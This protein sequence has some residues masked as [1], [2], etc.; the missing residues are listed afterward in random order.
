MWGKA[1]WGLPG[2]AASAQV[3][4]FVFGRPFLAHLAGDR[5][6]FTRPRPGYTAFLSRNL[7][8]SHG[9]DD[10]V[11]VRLTQTSG[12]HLLATHILGKSGL[13][14]TLVQA[15]GLIRIPAELEGLEAQTPVFV[16]PLWI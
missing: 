2:Q 16:E 5:Q 8:S 3:V 12:G 6:A 4:M 15:H 14:K 1:V 13:L 9:R 10:Y 7:A 11:R